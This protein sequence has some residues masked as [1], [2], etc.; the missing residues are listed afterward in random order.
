MSKKVPMMRNTK[1]GEWAKLSLTC[2]AN[3]HYYANGKK[4]CMNMVYQLIGENMVEGLEKGVISKE[5]RI[6]SLDNAV[7]ALQE[8]IDSYPMSRGKYEKI[9]AVRS[10][11][12]TESRNL[13]G[14]NK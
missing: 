9:A 10:Y 7:K 5:K 11:L 8:L 4:I 2:K 12:R 14:G 1:T 6:K 13:K 3:N